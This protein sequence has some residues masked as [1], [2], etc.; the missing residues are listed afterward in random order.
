M[1]FQVPFGPDPC[2][3]GLPERLCTEI[4]K[5]VAAFEDRFAGPLRIVAMSQGWAN[6]YRKEIERLVRT[7]YT[8][9]RSEHRG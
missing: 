3:A 9:G 7:A 8:V 4:E 6:D 1:D 2:H 5:S